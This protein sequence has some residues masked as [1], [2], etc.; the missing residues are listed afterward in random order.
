MLI[1]MLMALFNVSIIIHRVA[2]QTE[3]ATLWK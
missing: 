2:L 1:I 3:V